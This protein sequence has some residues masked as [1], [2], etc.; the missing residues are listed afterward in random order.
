MI[1]V[2]AGENSSDTELAVQ[3]RRS[4]QLGPVRRGLVEPRRKQALCGHWATNRDMGGAIY[5]FNLNFVAG[6]HAVQDI[7]LRLAR[8]G[9]RTRRA[10][11]ALA[12][13]SGRTSSRWSSS[14]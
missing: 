11:R 9:P 13:P 8:G 4:P 2:T 6:E 5:R 1:G 12:P 14:T 7:D 10:P 3:P